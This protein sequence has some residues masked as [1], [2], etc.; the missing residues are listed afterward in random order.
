MRVR[1]AFAHGRSSRSSNFPPYSINSGHR[2]IWKAREGERDAA[3]LLSMCRCI[4]AWH[5]DGVV[6]IKEGMHELKHFIDEFLSYFY[7]YQGF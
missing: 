2:I 6:Q 5:L 3:D 1:D 4:V 7:S